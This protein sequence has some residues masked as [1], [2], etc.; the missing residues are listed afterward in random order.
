M[1]T[2][3]LA[4]L[5]VPENTPYTVTIP[6]KDGNFVVT[7]PKQVWEQKPAFFETNLSKFVEKGRLTWGDS[8]P[9]NFVKP[10]PN[11]PKNITNI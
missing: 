2:G 6:N 10:G 9:P 7:V 4:G 8:L 11:D 5:N 1:Y 3:I